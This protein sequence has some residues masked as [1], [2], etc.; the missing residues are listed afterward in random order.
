MKV[1]VVEDD[2]VLARGIQ[3][4]LKKAGYVVEHEPMALPA[5]NLIENIMTRPDLIVLDLGLPDMDGLE[6]LKQIKQKDS[7]KSPLPVLILTARD[8]LSDKVTGLDIGGDDYLTKPFELDELL[9]RLRVLERRFR[10]AG[11]AVITLGK[12]SLDTAS[13]TMIFNGID[14]Y[15]LPRR[16][17]SLLRVLMENPG[18]IYSREQLIAKMYRW[19]EEVASNA[20]DVHLHSL[21][22]KVGSD[23]I[24]TVRGVGWLVERKA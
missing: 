24:R 11:S 13:Y 16:E 23:F 5:L 20:V 22:K 9:A 17:F 4:A 14:E 19:D 2:F 3:L 1:L 15:T 18:C 6:L 8:S 21:R 7:Q 12:V 10:N